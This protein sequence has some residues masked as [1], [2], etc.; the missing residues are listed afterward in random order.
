MCEVITFMATFW[1]QNVS[2][3]LNCE[4]WLCKDKLHGTT[5]TSVLSKNKGKA[6]NKQVAMR[7]MQSAF[8]RKGFF[9]MGITYESL[10][11]LSTYVV[12]DPTTVVTLSK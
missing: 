3:V 10:G 6:V 11:T 2:N 8:D 4:Q 5:E 7:R 1:A 9:I 12:C